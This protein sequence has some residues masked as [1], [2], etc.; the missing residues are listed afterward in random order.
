VLAVPSD[1]TPT[2]SAI[3]R[4]RFNRSLLGYRPSEV[5]EA[6]ASREAD[7]ARTA[8]E[9]AAQMADA[10]AARLRVTQLELV[11]ERLADRVL[12]RE[13]EL[14]EVQ[15][16][17]KRVRGEWERWSGSLAVIGEELEEVRRQARGQATRIRMQ[18]LREAA[19]LSDRISELSQRPAE[20][21][22]RLL[23][24]LGETIMRIGREEAE[25][26]E[27]AP[28]ATNGHRS[29]A[30]GDVFAGMVEVEI[31]PLDDFSQLVG[32]ED[33]MGGIGATREISVKRFAQ[34]RATLEM[35]LAEPVE[36]LREL[37][38]RAP[39]EFKVRDQRSD[40]LILDVDE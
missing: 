40:R 39:F 18:A 29:G 37:E 6:L 27:M 19:E 8:A 21:R 31:G 1:G 26:V 38:E 36:L 33:A 34:G 24:A 13:Y 30:P 17:L 28:A 35:K 7:V 14:A 9:L 20:T 12:G 15:A 22:E 2:V 23:D 25:T 32:F 11:A 5:D 16:E 3:A 4:G 10:D